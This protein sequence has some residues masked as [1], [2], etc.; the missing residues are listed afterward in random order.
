MDRVRRPVRL[1]GLGLMRH[2]LDGNEPPAL[3]LGVLA[4]PEL[5]ERM[6]L[7]DLVEVVD[8]RRRRRHPLERARIPRIVRSERAEA[9]GRPHRVDD[10][11]EDRRRDDERAQR[12]YLVPERETERRRVRVL[13]ADHP[14]QA[15][16]VH[17]PEGQVETDDHEPE[18][19][20]A[21]SFREQVTEHLRP[22]VVGRRE[23][24]EDRAPE[25]DVVEVRHDVVRVRLLVVGRDD[26][27][28]HAGEPPDDEHR[29]AADREH[30]RGGEP[31]VALVHRR[32]PVEDLHARR[33]GDDRRRDAERRVA[34]GPRPTANMWWAQTPKPMNPIAMPEN[35]TN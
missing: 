32:H 34:T 31:D 24:T 35:T 1:I 4:V 13:P 18:V 11:H 15:Q 5:V 12:G 29:H 9:H 16:D 7:R 21:Q 17:R 10:E 30:H 2:P 28:R 14:L 3:V 22:P 27:V 8:G 26:R 33:D 20:L 6:D 25:E 19:Q 23:Q